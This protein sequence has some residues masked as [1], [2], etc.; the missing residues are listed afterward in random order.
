MADLTRGKGINVDKSEIHTGLDVIR[1]GI[2]DIYIIK[3]LLV[4][5]GVAP[6]VVDG[7]IDLRSGEYDALY[8]AMDGS[9][10][11]DAVSR[12]RSRVEE[13]DSQAIDDNAETDPLKIIKRQLELIDRKLNQI[14]MVKRSLMIAGAARKMVGKVI[15]DASTAA[16]ELFM[17]ASE[18]EFDR[19]IAERISCL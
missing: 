15:D 12:E 16:N 2:K 9:A 18:D 4:T 10:F 8:L 17:N 3:R 19:M 7:F 6:D 14:M 13:T 1:G 11:D 5:N